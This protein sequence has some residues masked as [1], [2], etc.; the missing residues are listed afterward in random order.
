MIAEPTNTFVEYELENG[1]K[2]KM[3]LAYY[4]LYQLKTKNKDIYDRYNRIVPKGFTEELDGV[5]VAYTAYLCANL[6]NPEPY[7]EIDFMILLGGDRIK[8]GETVKQ[9][10][11][12]NEKH[13]IP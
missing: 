12:K 9:L 1:E 2:V 8:L 5:T 11:G 7:S 6:D 3:T 13:R 10:M 4:R